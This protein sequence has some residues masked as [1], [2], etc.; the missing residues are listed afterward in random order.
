MT[1]M[2]PGRRQTTSGKHMNNKGGTTMFKD[3]QATLLTM[4]ISTTCITLT[5][6]LLVYLYVLLASLDILSLV[7]Y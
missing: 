2:P 4:C 7:I 1:G 5:A 6:L 3:W